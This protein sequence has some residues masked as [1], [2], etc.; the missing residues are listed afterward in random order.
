MAAAVQKS[1]V[2]PADIPAAPAVSGAVVEALRVPAIT[3]HAFCETPEVTSAMQ[4]A[5]ADRR[6]SRTHATVHPGGIDAALALYR[7]TATPD[8]ILFESQVPAAQL[9]V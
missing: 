9:Y 7:K 2:A 1:T 6:M 3:L 8:L 5:V 4:S